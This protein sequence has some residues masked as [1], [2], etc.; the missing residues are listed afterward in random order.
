MLILS[1]GRPLN[2]TPIVHGLDGPLLCKPDLEDF[3]LLKT[4]V[5]RDKELLIDDE[6]ALESF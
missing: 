6:T 5:I 1:H 2:K 3:R 4:I